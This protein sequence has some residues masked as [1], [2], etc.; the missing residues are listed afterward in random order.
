MRK[1]YNRG[2]ESLAVEILFDYCKINSDS[3]TI[4]DLA[5]FAELLC[6][7]N[8]QFN[9]TAIREERDIYIK[10]FCDSLSGREFFN[11]TDRILEVGSGAGFPSVPLKIYNRALDFTLMEATGKKC[12][13]LKQAK[14]YLD[15]DKFWVINGRCE[16]LARKAPY[17]AAFD[18]VTA[19][20]VAEL[21]VLAEITLP[22]L[23]IGGRGVFYK[24]YSVSEIN[25]A[26]AA[27]ELLGG[28]IAGIKEYTLPFTEQKRCIIVIE[29]VAQTPEI[30]PRE[31]KTIK[32]RPL[33]ENDLKA[34]RG[35]MVS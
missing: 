19:R 21:N 9:L 7:K 32:K 3:A 10:H 26:K 17:R 31:Y 34:K 24:L 25:D 28:Q 30:F 35:G 22:Y 15:F 18:V 29:K 33:S 11:S 13:F 14:S 4:N 16:E 8:K 6:E 20:A 5:R 23:K 2:M 1:I 12:E 27:I